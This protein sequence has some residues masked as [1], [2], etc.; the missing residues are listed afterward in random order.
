M[1]QRRHPRRG[2]SLVELLIA[3]AVLAILGTSV[4]RL[5][6]WQSRF[7]DQQAQGRAARSASRSGMNMLLSELRMLDASGATAV[8]T[9]GVDSLRTGDVYLRVP[10]AFGIVCDNTG[11]AQLSI[12]ILPVDSLLYDDAVKPASGGFVGFAFRD[13][14]SGR[15]HYVER[16]TMPVITN[17]GGTQCAAVNIGAATQG[18]YVQ[19]TPGVP[20]GGMMPG[21]GAPVYLY[22]RIRYR[23]AASTSIPGTVALW[24]TIV[25]TGAD[26]EIAAPFDGTAQFRWFM[27]DNSAVPT[28]VAPAS[29]ADVRGLELLLNGISARIAE[30]AAAPASAPVSTSVF[31]KNRLD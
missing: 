10:F 24:R 20:V 27:K 13:S 2:Q 1:I 28:T 18:R 22:Q 12:S 3:L 25:R 21:A 11:G 4:T 7:Y 6:I 19:I 30:G 26:E 23:F 16:S 9:V 17:A 5:L 31:F 14:V 8:D 15:Y 29:L